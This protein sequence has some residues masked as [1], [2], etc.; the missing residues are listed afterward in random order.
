MMFVPMVGFIGR[1]RCRLNPGDVV[2]PLN[3]DDAARIDVALST[4]SP[5]S[6]TRLVVG[7]THDFEIVKV[8]GVLQGQV[9]IER[10]QE[11]TRPIAAAP[12]TCVAF[13]WTAQN[14]IDFIGQ[15]FG[16]KPAR[17]AMLSPDRHA[18]RSH[19]PIAT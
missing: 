15:G 16:G 3:A 8:T 14:L 2:L 18:S 19:V 13:V 1:L 10:A 7:D 12:G 11:G 17:C 9:T 6:F 5:T 4:G